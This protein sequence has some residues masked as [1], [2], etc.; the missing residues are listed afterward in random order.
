MGLAST[1]SFYSGSRRR[2]GS[3]MIRSARVDMASASDVSVDVNSLKFTP[4]PTS[5]PRPQPLNLRPSLKM[6]YLGQ[7]HWKTDCARVAL[8]IAG[9]PLEE[10]RVGKDSDDG[11][12]P[13][14]RRTFGT[15]PALV[16]GGHGVI[17]QSQSI[18][19][20]VGQITD[21][22]PKDPF[23]AAKVDECLEAI[24]AISEH[25]HT[26]MKESDPERKLCLRQALIASSGRITK[27]LGGLETLVKQNAAVPIPYVAGRNLSMADLALWGILKWL[28][29]GRVDGIPQTY[30]ESNFPTLWVLTCAVDHTPQVV[31]WMA[32]HPR[33]NARSAKRALVV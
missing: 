3:T 27:R 19:R 1:L 32:M 28:G 6:I 24:A 23:M 5:V 14:V 22:Y 7:Q 20:Y 10:A 15:F 12:D 33:R 4:F 16:V 30:V 25:L 18:A 9:I 31:E 21:L 2:Q 29:S 17:N 8:H 11:S 13:F 26:T